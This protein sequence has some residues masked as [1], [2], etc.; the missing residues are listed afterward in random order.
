M[1]VLVGNPWRNQRAEERIR[2]TDVPLMDGGSG[3]PGSR[4]RAASVVEKL[5]SLG[6]QLLLANH[7]RAACRYK[8]PRK[9]AATVQV[10]ALP[11]EGQRADAFLARLLQRSSQARGL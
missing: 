3:P 7:N 9:L 2:E 11:H 8:K 6:L 5:Q 4:S 10:A 1:L